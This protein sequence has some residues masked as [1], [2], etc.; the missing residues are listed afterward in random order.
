LRARAGA[1]VAAVYALVTA[2]ERAG[3]FS[4][5]TSDLMAAAR[6]IARADIDRATERELAD[7]L[8]EAPV[9]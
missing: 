7:A 8:E 3:T 6:G 4:H 2:A 5:R 9:S 1:P